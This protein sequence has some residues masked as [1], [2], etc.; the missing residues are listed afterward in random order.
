MSSVIWMPS[1]IHIGTRK[2]YEQGQQ[3]VYNWQPAQSIFM[4][5]KTTQF[6]V[7]GQ[8]LVIVINEISSVTW[9]VAVEGVLTD[10]GFTARRP[11]FRT[12][13]QFWTPGWHQWQ[14]N[15][16]VDGGDA[17]WDTRA[18]YLLSAKTKIPEDVRNVALTAG[19]HLA[20]TE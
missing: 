19:L 14:L 16:K 6:G 8:N 17:D 20:L 18:D 13:E 10:E 4:C 3:Y 7:G 1:V 9:F 11:A 12:R 2:Y 15:K 5:D